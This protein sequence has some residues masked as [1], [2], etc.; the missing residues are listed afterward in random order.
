MAKWYYLVDGQETGPIEPAELKRLADSGCV[1]PH[2]QLRREDMTKWHRANEV[3][4]LFTNRPSHSGPSSAAAPSAAPDQIMAPTT[5]GN[6]VRGAATPSSRAT[7][8][9]SSAEAN[10]NPRSPNIGIDGSANST[11]SSA[12][13]ASRP[14]PHA[15]DG[16]HER[17]SSVWTDL[18]SLNFWEEIIPI[19]STNVGQMLKDPVIIAVIGAA[20]TPLV[21]ITLPP[22]EQ[23]TA[24][25]MLFAFLWGMVFRHY[26]V[27]TSVA[28]NILLASLFFTGLVG[29]CL[30]L[31]AYKFVLPRFYLGLPV[32]S[33]SVVSLVGLV[34]QTGICEEICKILPVLAYL[35]WKR[36]NADPKV[37]ILIGVFSG[38]GFAAFENLAYEGDAIVRALGLTIT[39]GIPG[40]REGVE[41]A[42]INTLTRS[43]SLVFCHALW[44]GIFAYFLTVAFLTGRRYVALAL[45]GLVVSATLHGVYDWLAG[46]QQTFAAALMA[47]TFVLFYAYLTKLRSLTESGPEM[48]KSVKDES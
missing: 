45:T 40:L 20:I 38:L 27:R 37:C 24:F 47:A 11:P 10:D 30:L 28:W 29:M 15:T 21:I 26:I 3:K 5:N 19:D 33:I 44:T 13:S 4:G 2:D 1:K 8:G 41:G 42:M 48:S 36:S 18:R 14:N 16:I 25:A 46:M 6:G 35:A 17:L 12:A 23:L 7:K 34:I 22:N 31:A 39:R 43:L 32:S 9:G